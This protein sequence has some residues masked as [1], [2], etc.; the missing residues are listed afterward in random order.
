MIVQNSRPSFEVENIYPIPAQNNILIDIYLSDYQNFKIEIYSLEG[1]VMK[2]AIQLGNAG[3]NRI[4]MDLS[5]FATGV[6]W[7]Q[8][9][10]RMDSFSQK[11]IKAL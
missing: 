10:S 9:S 6:Y 4:N 5:D 7:I 2:Q 1:K 8:V 3:L 11:I